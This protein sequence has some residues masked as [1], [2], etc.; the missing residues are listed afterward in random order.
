MKTRILENIYGDDA[1]A[2]IMADAK[3]RLANHAR[4]NK[5]GN[6]FAESGVSD[7]VSAPLGMLGCGSWYVAYFE[8]VTA[9]YPHTDNDD[10]NMKCVVVIPLYWDTSSI[11]HTVI[12]NETSESKVILK[13]RT[14]VTYEF[15]YE[16]SMNTGVAF[17][18]NRF[19]S[20]D[21]FSGIKAGIQVIGYR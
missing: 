11:P 7:L 16:W 4:I 2:R 15:D 12:H 8:H 17:D 10:P 20:S 13:D 6:R 3:D 9:V 19:H 21:E 14:S 18:A 1:L 5:V